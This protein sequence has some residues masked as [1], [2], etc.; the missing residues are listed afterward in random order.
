MQVEDLVVG[1]LYGVFV[2]GVLEG[3]DLGGAI[4][5]GAGIGEWL[6]VVVGFIVGACVGAF[7]GAVGADVVGAFVPDGTVVW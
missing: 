2:V 3:V 5:T 7:V 1:D 4:G 6:G